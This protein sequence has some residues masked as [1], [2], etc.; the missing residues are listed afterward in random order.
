ML[1]KDGV[2]VTSDPSY[3]P[4]PHG[5]YHHSLSLSSTYHVH[6]IS[7]P[8]LWVGGGVCLSSRD[9]FLGN[10][11]CS[12]GHCNCLGAYT[13]TYCQV[14]QASLYIY[15]LPTSWT[16]H[17]SCTGLNTRRWRRWSRRPNSSNAEVLAP[18]QSEM[19]ATSSSRLTSM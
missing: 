1:S 18:N 14:G 3:E 13:G 19:V 7:S 4:P 2:K 9:C 17:D 12:A 5:R 8:S 11:T 10:G 6:L 16:A 15:M